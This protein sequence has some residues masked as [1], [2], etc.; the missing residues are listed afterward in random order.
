LVINSEPFMCQLSSPFSV[1]FSFF[2]IFLFFLACNEIVSLVYDSN[3][4]EVPF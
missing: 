4:C 3:M 1:F 2:F